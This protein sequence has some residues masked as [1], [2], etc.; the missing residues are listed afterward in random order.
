MGGSQALINSA[1]FGRGRGIAAADRF[2][3]VRKVLK[4][5]GDRAVLEDLLRLFEGL[6][7]SA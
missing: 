7:E 5:A 4:L 3:A 1:A 2:G 6:Q